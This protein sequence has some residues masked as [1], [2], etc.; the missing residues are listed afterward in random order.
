MNQ[1]DP[2]ME[3]I[4]MEAQSEMISGVMH[5]C[6]DKTLNKAHNAA[7]LSQT[8]QTQ[9]TNC[10]LKFMESPNI[11][12]SSAQSFNPNNFWVNRVESKMAIQET[13]LL[14]KSLIAANSLMIFACD[15]FWALSHK[16]SENDTKII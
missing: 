13:N 9:F 11:I 8:E 15:C 4:M 16:I 10:V 3:R 6:R 2:A 12:M 14:R 5:V 1:M 7:S